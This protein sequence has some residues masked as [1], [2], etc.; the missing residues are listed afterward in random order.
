VKK[1]TKFLKKLNFFFDAGILNSMH[2][3]NYSFEKPDYL[4]KRTGSSLGIL[5]LLILFLSIL[6][7]TWVEDSL[8]FPAF[9]III[10]TAGIFEYLVVLPFIHENMNSLFLSLNCILLGVGIIV[11]IAQTISHK[12]SIILCIVVL[13]SISLKFSCVVHE[14]RCANIRNQVAILL[15]KK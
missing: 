9:A 12:F 13:V 10:S 7:I 3:R 4:A 1:N 6:L 2:Q 5:R 11:G 8:I 14:F 15:N